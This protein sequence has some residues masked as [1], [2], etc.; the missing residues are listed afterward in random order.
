M[1]KPILFILLLFIGSCTWKQEKIKPSIENISE[2]IYASGM[3]KSENQYQAFATVN[4]IINKI[5]VAEGDTV[6]KGAIILTISNETQQLNKDN[7]ALTAAFSAIEAN[8]GKL[9]EAKLAIGLARDKMKNDSL[10]LSRQNTLWNQ[11]VGTKVELEQRALAYQ[12]SKNAYYS[13]LVRFN[14]LK[15]QLNFNSAQSKNNLQISNKLEK[16]YLLKSEINGIVYQIPLKV[17][18]FVNAQ[19]PLAVIGDAKNFILEMQVDEYDILKVKKGL[20]VLVTMD[21]YK[22]Q[23]FEASV[24]K[25]N[26][27]M[28]E[29]SK[30]FLVEAQFIITPKTIYPNTS[31][32]ANI[33]V[34]S[35]KKALLIPRNYLM[36][37]NKV[38]KENGDTVTVKTGLKDYQ[39]VEILSGLTAADQLIKPL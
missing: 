34:Q 14:D 32:E 39:K 35:K 23:V 17:G 37:D 1:V 18:E 9:E 4:G 16:D 7:A 29:K 26:P 25:I 19:L 24:T 15:R 28:N 21:T 3:V 20:P 13:A 6:K 10:L 31:F 8:K 5:F 38:I 36:K 33:V 11:N 27:L 30:T 12:N 2:S 22:G